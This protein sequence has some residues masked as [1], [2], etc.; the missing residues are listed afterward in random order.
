M[1]IGRMVGNADT[2]DIFNLMSVFALPVTTY[3]PA[4]IFH[5]YHNYRHAVEINAA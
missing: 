2:A 5:L 4:N 3:N 1:S